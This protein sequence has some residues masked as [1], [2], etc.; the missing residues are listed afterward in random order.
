M[1]ESLQKSMLEYKKQLE[2]GSIQRAYRGLMDYMMG[3]RTHFAKKY[4]EY[5]VSA[6]IYY[7]YMDMTY[8]SVVPQSMKERKLKIPIVFQH[9]AFRFEVWL[10]GANRKTQQEYWELLDKSGWD[11]YKIVPQGTWVDSILEYILIDDPDFGELDML[12][13]QIEQGTLR[14]IEDVES[15]LSQ[16]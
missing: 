9:E 10:S 6:S 5:S 15:F 14:F 7:G 2:R 12:T 1:V 4:P 3:L 13:Q 8:F 11:K 16:H